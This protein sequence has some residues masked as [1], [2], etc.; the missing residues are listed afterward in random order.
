MSLLTSSALTNNHN[1]Y[2][3][4]DE[5]TKILH[6][7]SK[8]VSR[9]EWKDYAINFDKNNAFFYIFKHSLA[10]PDC[11]L[12]KKIEKKRKKVFYFLIFNN[13]RKKFESIDKL[14]FYLNRMN[15]KVINK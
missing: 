4:K 14:I 5:L 2:F 6:V 8:G 15:F 13:L 10:S 1:I 7:Y 11:V 3:S 12:N 9:G